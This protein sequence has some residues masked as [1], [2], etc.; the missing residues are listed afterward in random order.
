M[1]KLQLVHSRDERRLEILSPKQV[2]VVLLYPV[3]WLSAVAYFTSVVCWNLLH[4]GD[5]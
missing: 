3:L 4:S 1:T 2:G 5:E